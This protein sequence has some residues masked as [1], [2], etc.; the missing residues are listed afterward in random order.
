MIALNP[1][2]KI[3]NTYRRHWFILFL[4]IISFGTAI[5]I[6]IASALVFFFKSP[7][8]E[9]KMLALFFSSVIILILFIS[10]CIGFVDYWLDTWLVTNDRIIDIE[11]KGLFVRD[12]SEFKI[13]KIQNINVIVAGFI[14]TMLNYGNLSVQTAGTNETFVFRNIPN[15]YKA[16]TDILAIYDEYIK[17]HRQQTQ[18][19]HQPN[20]PEHL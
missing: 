15:P 9:Y 4:E 13:S 6:T 12:F 1:G 18:S 16:K 14:P 10:F 11:Q 7:N 17:L 5:I 20:H 19:E 8:Y 2:E 3:I